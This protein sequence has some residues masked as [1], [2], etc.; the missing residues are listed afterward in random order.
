MKGLIK[1]IIMTSIISS[2]S[3]TNHIT[4]EVVETQRVNRVVEVEKIHIER[5]VVTTNV[6]QKEQL[7][8]F[9]NVQNKTIHQPVNMVGNIID[10]SA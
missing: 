8:Y 7:N 9:Y 1:D 10:T 5:D 3:H 4:K 6:I 2:S